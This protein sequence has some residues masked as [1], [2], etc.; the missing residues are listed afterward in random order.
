MPISRRILLFA[1]LGGVLTLSGC[2]SRTFRSYYAASIAPEVSR[3]WRVTDVRVSVPDSLVVSEQKSLVPTADIVWRE[4]PVGD[5][6]P[7]VAAIVKT[8]AQQGARGLNGPRGVVLEITVSRFHA[9]TFEA[10]T[11]LSNSGVHNIDFVIEVVDARSGAIL[12]GPDPIEAALPALSGPQMIAAR[13]RGETQKSQ[14]TSHLQRVIA[15]WLGA[16]PDVRDSF[17]RAGI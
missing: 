15:G 6:R 2:V 10:E 8:A 12:A 9:L 4:D 11:R 1:G 5:R 17:K 14:I 7:Q 3:G 16:G 13:E